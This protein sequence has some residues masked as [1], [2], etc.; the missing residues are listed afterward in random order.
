MKLARFSDEEKVKMFDQLA[1]RFFE[2]NFGQASKADIELLMFRF[3]LEKIVSDAKCSDGTIDYLKCSDYQISKDLGITQQ[4]VRNLKI[5]KELIYPSKFDWQLALKN[6]L[7]NARYERESKKICLSILD[8]NLYYEVENFF[9]LHGAAIEKTLNPKILKLRVEYFIQ[10]LTELEAENS[11]KEILKELK[12]H[13]KQ[14]EKDEISFD[15]NSVGKKLIDA[16]VN[17]TSIVSNITGIASSSK[18][19]WEL[20][21][22]IIK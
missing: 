9:D 1:N 3:Y 10:L 21:G 15:E 14:T 8:P 13:I 6:L 20:F 5:K 16:G 4:K 11:K 17:I 19:L 2:L 18:I 22:Q 7:K 12:R